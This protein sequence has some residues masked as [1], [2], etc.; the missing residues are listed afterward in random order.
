MTRFIQLHALTFYPPSN[1]NRDD[2]G[3]P[4]KATVGNMPRL[5]ISSQCLKRSWRTSDVFKAALSDHTGVRTRRLA[6]EYQRGLENAGVKPETAAK[7][8]LKL[9]SAF[10]SSEINDPNNKKDKKKAEEDGAV[11]LKPVEVLT[12]QLV[13]LGP[14]EQQMIKELAATLIAEKREP[15]KEELALLTKNHGAVD[16]ALFGRMLA[17]KT[18]HNVEAAAQVS[19]AFTVNKVSMEDDYFTA[20]DDLNQPGDDLGAA[21]IGENSFGSGVYYLYVCINLDQFRENLSGCDEALISKSLRALTEAIATVSPS[22]KQNSFAALARAGFMLAEKTNKAPRSLSA[23][24]M[25]PVS[26]DLLKNAVKALDEHR[27][28]MDTAYDAAPDADYRFFPH[29][30]EGTLAALLDF[31]GEA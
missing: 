4:K 26:Q 28:L 10:A 17:D 5:R 19:H 20:V 2:L 8:A 9:A 21:H 31:V 30:G 3:Q 1:L 7:H 14:Y 15:K 18:Q 16:V 29:N 6:I 25:Q 13:H 24:F 11:E 23:A 22:G 27:T 12:K